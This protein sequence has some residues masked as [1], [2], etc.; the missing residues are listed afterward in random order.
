VENVRRNIVVIGASAGGVSALRRIVVDLPPKFPETVLI[1]LHIGANR[2]LL[3]AVLAAAGPN[4]AAHAQDGEALR[5]GHLVVAP[6]DYHL[7]LRAGCLCL[8]QGP[9]EHFT[10]PAIGPLFRSAA[11]E[12]GSRVIGILLTGKLD[13]GIAGLK[14]IRQCGGLAIV[15]DPVSAYAPRMPARAL[16]QVAIDYCLPLGLIGNRLT[17]LVRYMPVAQSINN[18]KWWRYIGTHGQSLEKAGAPK[19]ALMLNL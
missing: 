13:D 10:R 16:R 12:H 8:T 11:L 9:R 19:C 5:R 17:D 15:Q 6:P 4:T 18:P 2:S 14:A 3:P 7:L 1:V